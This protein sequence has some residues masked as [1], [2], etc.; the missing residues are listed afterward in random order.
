MKICYIDLQY[1]S[2]CVV[3]NQILKQNRDICLKEDGKYAI[4]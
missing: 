1:L 3:F 4:C 2:A